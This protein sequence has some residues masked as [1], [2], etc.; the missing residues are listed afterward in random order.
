MAARDDAVSR[1]PRIQQ[2]ISSTS[3]G[4]IDQ[5]D[6]LHGAAAR[7]MPAR[8]TGR[9]F[10]RMT[11]APDRT[12][13]QYEPEGRPKCSSALGQTQVTRQAH[14]PLAIWGHRDQPYKGA[15]GVRHRAPCT[16]VDSARHT[17]KWCVSVCHGATS[18][19]CQG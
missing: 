8:N 11:S 19:R 2:R 9:Y 10:E 4:G 16:D 17:G 12:P 7:T 15:G 6:S 5:K 13:V 3:G 18:E 14:V 1:I